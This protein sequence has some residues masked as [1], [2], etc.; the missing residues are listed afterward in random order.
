MNLLKYIFLG[1]EI[2]TGWILKLIGIIAEIIM[3]LG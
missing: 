2:A 1:F 3:S